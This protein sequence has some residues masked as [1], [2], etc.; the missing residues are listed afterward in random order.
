MFVFIMLKFLI[1]EEN[2]TFYLSDQMNALP[3][4]PVWHRGGLQGLFL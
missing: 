3:K 1:A 2:L 4:V